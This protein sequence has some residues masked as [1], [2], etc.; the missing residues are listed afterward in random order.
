MSATFVETSR[1]ERET[2][3]R[4]WR[5]LDRESTLFGRLASFVRK[6]IL[7]RAVRHYT[8]RYFPPRG[9]FVEMGCGTAQASASIEPRER[10]FAG[11]DLS[12]PALLAAR[13]NPPH[14][15]V[16]GGDLRHLPFPD[17][18]V[19]GIWNLGVMEHFPPEQGIEILRELGRVLAPGAYAILFW[20]PSFG[21]SRWVLA[22]VEWVRTRVSGQPFHFFP[23]EVN[24]LTSR[25]HA[26]R[27]VLAGGLEPVAVDFSFRDWLIHMVVVARRP[28]P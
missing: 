3:D 20:P 24:R 4:H 2:W 6:G 27:M 22:P 15:N 10:R 5:A 17:G 8:E 1:R 28:G 26:R 23:D 12:L 7:R 11:L 13:G 14:Q 19:A 18:S 25:D 9:L 16:L 21:S